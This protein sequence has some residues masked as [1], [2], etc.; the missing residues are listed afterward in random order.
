MLLSS[1]RRG[2]AGDAVLSVRD[3][4]PG[5]PAAAAASRNVESGAGEDKGT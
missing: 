5:T 2:V 1:I 4:R 3:A